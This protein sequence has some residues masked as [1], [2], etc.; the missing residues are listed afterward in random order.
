MTRVA[1]TVAGSVTLM[2]GIGWLGLQLKPEPFPPPSQSTGRLSTAEM[3]ADLPEPVERHFRAVFGERVTKS[4]TAVVRGRAD[5]KI[6]GLW[7]PMRFESYHESGRAFVRNMEITWF[8]TPVLRG[9]DAYV[10]GKGTL[11]ISGLVNTSDEGARMDQGENLALWAEAPFTTPSALVLDPRVR[12]EPVDADSARLVVPF[13][14]R[15]ET[16]QIE[17]DPDTGFM[18]SM[19][20]MRYREQEQAKTPWRAEYSRWETVHGIRVPHRNAAIWEDEGEPYIVLDLDGV[21]YDVDVS[22][23]LP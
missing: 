22:E 21:E 5:F 3:P 9:S 16:L 13:G 23:E 15:E 17:F 19:S 14:E 11:K 7:T 10:G 20:G 6:K 12:W 1:V 8:G 2:V 4:E 18:R